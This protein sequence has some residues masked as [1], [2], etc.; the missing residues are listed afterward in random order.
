MKPLL[1]GVALLAAACTS[2]P[3]FQPARE[4][5]A[6]RP[7]FDVEHYRIE[8]TLN[9][10]ERSLEGECRV[11]LWPTQDGLQQ[12]ELDLQGLQVREV[13]DERERVLAHTHEGDR[14]R[15]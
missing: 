14:L 15:V 4:I 10:A 2:T 1:L 7:A 8:L 5:V 12:V 3:A 11:R 6:R 13:R 9:P